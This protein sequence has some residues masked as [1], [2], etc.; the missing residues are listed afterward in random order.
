[1]PAQPIYPW[2][3]RAASLGPSASARG[4]AGWR[5]FPG[6]ERSKAHPEGLYVH[7]GLDAL[8]GARAHLCNLCRGSP[9][10]RVPRHGLGRDQYSC[11]R[12]GGR[13]QAKSQRR[14]GGRYASKS[15]QR[16]SQ[17]GG[18][19]V[20]DKRRSLLSELLICFRRGPAHN[21]PTSRFSA[22]QYCGGLG[23]W[24]PV[25]PNQTRT[26]NLFAPSA[27]HAS[28]FSVR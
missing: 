24:V 3:R 15:D 18:I 4:L 19:S 14:P 26:Q 5:T 10:I 8:S 22:I 23:L 11:R 21:S 25:S 17:F 20:S 2:T 6:G 13:M 9:P 7:P 12:L 27:H 16:F 1:V 28:S